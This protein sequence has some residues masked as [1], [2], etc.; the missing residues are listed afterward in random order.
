M[1]SIAQNIDKLLVMVFLVVN[2]I[3]VGK[4]IRKRKY[5]Y[6]GKASNERKNSG[7]GVSL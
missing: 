6:K 5:V 2:A 4:G 7:L 1:H 3:Q